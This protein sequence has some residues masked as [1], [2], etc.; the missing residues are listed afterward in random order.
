MK[1]DL[2]SKNIVIDYKGI[3]V[4]IY[5]LYMLA[6]I[7]GLLASGIG[8]I[9]AY[10][11]RK[12]AGTIASTHLTFQIRGFWIG[13]LYFFIAHI[14]FVAV[15]AIAIITSG[16]ASI[17]FHLASNLM[18]VTLLNEGWQ[19]MG[20]F[21]ISRQ[22]NAAFGLFRFNF[23]MPFD[24]FWDTSRIPLQGMFLPFNMGSLGPMSMIFFGWW[25]VRNARGL[26]YLLKN[27]EVPNTN[28]WFI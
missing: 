17:N 4:T 19:L 10:L 12:K 25:V 14:I 13:I 5:F 18:P 26:Y 1:E 2:K 28:S 27:K 3:L 20:Y 24:A 22:P 8:V 23:V 11:L 7:L 21:D 9:I 16:E 15:F 6:I